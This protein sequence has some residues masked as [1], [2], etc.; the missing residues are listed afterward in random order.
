MGRGEEILPR[1]REREG[2]RKVAETNYVRLHTKFR[3]LKEL[4]LKY[5]IIPLKKKKF[6]KN[7]KVES[8]NTRNEKGQHTLTD[9]AVLLEKPR[10]KG[11]SEC[12]I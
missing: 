12:N 6:L 2:K 9:G 8:N 10:R 11:E 1:E 4:V 3:E 7:S 5:L